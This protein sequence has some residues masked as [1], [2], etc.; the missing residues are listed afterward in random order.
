MGKIFAGLIFVFFH[1][2][3]N[4]FDLLP[5]F[6]GYLLIWLGMRSVTESE[7]WKNSQSALAACIVE[8]AVLALSLTGASLTG[9][10][11]TVL[12]LALTV[13]QLVVTYII[14]RGVEEAEKTAGADLR[15]G[16]LRKSWYFTMICTAASYV[17]GLIQSEAAVIPMILAFMGI[18]CYIVYYY[19]AWKAYDTWREEHFRAI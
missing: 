4:G 19:K 18:V 10:A 12:G 5:D 8:G 2:R 17:C 9:A 13:L 14:V 7:I 6:V 16:E 3:I 11:G 1:F 15:A